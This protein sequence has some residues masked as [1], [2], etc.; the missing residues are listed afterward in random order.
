MLE[1]YILKDR[2]ID[3]GILIY[4]TE[5]KLF[6]FKANMNLDND[7]LLPYL[8]YP[9][10]KKNKEYIPI[11]KAIRL[12]VQDR[13]VP[14]ERD[15]IENI[16]RRL[17]LPVYDAWAICKMTRG[18]CMEDYMWLAK[19]GEEFE[20]LHMRYLREHGQDY[21]VRGIFDKFEEEFHGK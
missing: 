18:M 11:D 17:K 14:E 20:E 4:D 10:D 9:Y 7:R 19:P 13:V 5:E 8:I 15:D 12:F 2:D 3:L 16:L 21:K 1:S 6:S